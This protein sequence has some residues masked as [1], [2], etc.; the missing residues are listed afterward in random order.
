M[1][2]E[3]Q[4]PLAPQ[5]PGQ[6]VL[7]LTLPGLR[8]LHEGQI[9]GRRVKLPVQLGRRPGEPESRIWIPSTAA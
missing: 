5:Q 1:S 3:P 4:R 6:A 7:A 2:G 8:L 9:E